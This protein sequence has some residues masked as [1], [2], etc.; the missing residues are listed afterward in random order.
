MTANT[1]Q[2]VALFGP[3]A[4]ESPY[5]I[6]DKISFKDEK[7]ET[8]TGLITWVTAAHKDAK[9]RIVPLTYVVWIEGTLFPVFVYPSDII[10]D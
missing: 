9:D 3:M 2:M 1:E 8:Q 10:T 4:E 6:D 5:K 7:G